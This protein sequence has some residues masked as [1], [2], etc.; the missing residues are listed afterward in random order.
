MIWTAIAILT[1]HIAAPVEPSVDPSSLRSLTAYVQHAKERMAELRKAG[2]EGSE[3]YEEYEERAEFYGMRQH[4]LHVRA[5]PNDRID[6]EAHIEAA[7]HRDEMPPVNSPAFAGTSWTFFGPRNQQPAGGISAP[8]A[9]RVN[10]VKHSPTDPANDFWVAAAT[11]G[12]FKTTDGAT[13]F[14]ALSSSWP[15]SYASDIEVDPGNANRVYVATG[16]FPGWWGYGFGMMRST[17]G[18]STWINELQSQLQGCEV[19]D[20]LVDPDSPNIVFAAA[21]RGTGDPDGLGLW[22]STDY[23]NNWTRVLDNVQTGGV[24]S[25]A[26][27]I[28]SNGVRRIYAGTMNGR[29][30]VSSNKFVSNSSKSIGGLGEPIAVATSTTARD[31]VYAAVMGS[32]SVQRSTDAG[33]SYS[34][35]TTSGL[36]WNQTGFN[37]LFG[38][39]NTASNGSGSD[40]LVFGMTEFFVLLPGASSWSTPFGSG[41]TRTLHVDHHGFDRHPT[42]QNFALIGNDGGIYR[43]IYVSGFGFTLTNLNSALRNTEHVHASVAPNLDP[44]YCMTGMWHLGVGQSIGDPWTW[45]QRRGGDGMY[46]IIHGSLQT[47]QF[48][49][50]QQMWSG[51][52]DI[53]ISA[54]RDGWVNSTSLNTSYYVAGESFAF[55]TPM[56][57]VLNDPGAAYFAGEYLYKVKYTS[58]GATWTKG[59]G[60]TDL[61]PDTNEAVLSLDSMNNSTNGVY[62]GTTNGRVMGTLD[63]TTG[64]T[65]IKDYSDPVTCVSTNP[66]DYDEVLIALGNAGAPGGGGAL[67]EITDWSNIILRKE[68]DRSGSG[69]TALP[70]TG[71]NWVERDPYDPV[72]TWYAATDLGVF[73]TENRGDDWYNAT[74]S[75]GLPNVMCLHLVA[76]NGYLYVSTFGR[77]MWRMALRSTKPKIASF[78]ITQTFITGGNPI[79]GTVTLDKTAGPG[80]VAVTVTSSDNSAVFPGVVVVPQGQTSLTWQLGTGQVTQHTN[81]TVTCSANGGQASDTVL[82]NEVSVLSF[83]LDTNITAGGGFN[84]IVYLDRAAPTGGVT[85]NLAASPSSAVTIPSQITISAGSAFRQFSGTAAL[86]PQNRNVGIQATKPG[87]GV[88]SNMVIFGLYMTSM[89]VSPNPVYNTDA[90]FVN[91]TLNRP[92]SE[93][94]FPLTAISGNT[95]VATVLSPFSVG[96]NLQTGNTVGQSYYVATDSAAGIRVT[97]PYGDYL[98]DVVSVEHLGFQGLTCTPNPVIGGNPVTLRV[99]LDRTLARSTRVYLSSSDSS[100]LSVPVFATVPVGASFVDVAGTTTT[101]LSPKKVDVLVRLKNAP[102]DPPTASVTV[103]VVPP[104]FVVPPSSFTVSLGRKDAGD[105]LSL[106]STDGNYLRVCKFIV[107]NSVVPPINVTVEG[108]S[109]VASATTLQWLFASKMQHAGAFSQTLEFWNWQTGA[110]DTTNLRTDAVTTTLVERSLAGSGTLSRL[111]DPA[112]GNLRC[113]YTVKSTGPT[114]VSAWCHETDRAV[115]LLGF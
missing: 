78:D 97:S 91:V 105:V 115:W 37:Y 24:C 4:L 80:G 27:S 12:V 113:R 8:V 40:L 6:R 39:L 33:G 72:N 81:T 21:G 49:T 109:S 95:N 62:V 82:V 106:R 88:Q 51:S 7:K 84:G 100:I 35:V 75:L 86:T 114:A 46:S 89:S 48:A 108:T 43:I 85:V 93:N 13:N 73:Y 50:I 101:V 98:E 23:G 53:G 71:V 47:T 20:I 45:Y 107:P 65:F 77:G 92:A 18:G 44:D 25:L 31:T 87:S 28:S 54:T 16:D 19:A 58:A 111:L 55:I 32:Q 34:L 66:N 36:A 52:S 30:Y 1:A 76:R 83:D 41:G 102:T 96:A 42:L 104:S 10:A 2:K 22:K 60:G 57:D 11:G 103:D 68:Y 63:P 69:N 26:A 99:R 79:T 56:D 64:F 110:W 61:C 17:D 70:S 90:F 38:V 5:W 67:K 59:I 3:E 9:G 94:G 14:T 112:T 15:Y 74:A 29:L